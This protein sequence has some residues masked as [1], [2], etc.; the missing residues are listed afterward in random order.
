MND[1]DAPYFPDDT[2]WEGA[3]DSIGPPNHETV[4]GGGQRRDLI[5]QGCRLSRRVLEETIKSMDLLGADSC[6]EVCMYWDERSNKCL[7]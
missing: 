7:L 5:L 4:R 1:E 2:W 3:P 6:T